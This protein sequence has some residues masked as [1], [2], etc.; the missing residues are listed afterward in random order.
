MATDT[1]NQEPQV[2]MQR[3]YLKEIS[4]EQPNAPLIYLETEMPALDVQLSI[5]NA[6]IEDRL[7][8]VSVVAHVHTKL[9]DKTVFLVEAKQSAVFEIRNIPEE[10]IPAILAITCPQ[11]IY[12]YLRSNVADVISR[13]GLPSVHLSEVNFQA[14]YEQQLQANAAA[15]TK[16]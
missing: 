7:F 1:T 14:L 12:P 10:Q 3:M 9:K 8:E 11:L 4:L 2:L 13:T 6:A 5:E 15:L 16:A